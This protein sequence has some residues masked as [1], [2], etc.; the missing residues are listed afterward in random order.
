ML[1]FVVWFVVLSLAACA[2][3]KLA[4]N[5]NQPI[6]VVLNATGKT[7]G[8][9][10]SAAKSWVAETRIARMEMADADKDSSRII[11]RGNGDRP[12][13]STLDCLNYK[14]D[15][16]GF[17]LRI[18]T[19]DGKIKMTFTNLKFHS[20]VRDDPKNRS[21]ILS[22]LHTRDGDA[23]APAVTQN[24]IDAANR[25]ANALANELLAYATKQSGGSW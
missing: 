25:G 20:P 9:L 6:E 19:K 10:F 15:K 11:V 17:T 23:Y 8:Q 2:D 13:E 16:I 21:V 12:C 4:E 5:P 18:D 1:R 14:D 22:T 3:M 24:D 7:Q